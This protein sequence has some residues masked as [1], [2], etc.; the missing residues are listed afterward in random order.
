MES[1]QIGSSGSGTRFSPVKVWAPPCGIAALILLFSSLPGTYYPEHQ[2]YIN[3]GVH[4]L[5]FG[6]LAFLLARALQ[7]VY[8]FSRLGLFLW[9]TAV[10]ASFGLLD[11]VHQFLV[12]ERAFD[13]MDLLFDTLGAAIGSGFFIF[14]S[15][16]EKGIFG[17]RSASSGD[18]DV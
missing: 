8:S 13:L 16:F 6:L 11:E 9:T 2:D 15:T 5:E 3:N 12:P 18:L 14:M 17:N 1:E 10:C 7:F 4:F